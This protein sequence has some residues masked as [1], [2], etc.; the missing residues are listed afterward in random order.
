DRSE[1]LHHARMVEAG[2]QPALDLEAGGVALVE[3]AL[4]RHLA[5]V[6]VDG[7]V[8]AP[9]RALCR[10]RAEPIAADELRTRRWS[11]HA[12]TVAQRGTAARN[13]A[14]APTTTAS[15]PSPATKYVA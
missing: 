2:E 4:R 8:D 14:V 10:R 5:A 7:F 3:Q 12:P 13:A 1:H 6:G 15:A 9:H 11:V